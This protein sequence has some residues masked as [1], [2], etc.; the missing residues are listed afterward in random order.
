[1]AGTLSV[2]LGI[3]G[4]FLPILPT[5][6]FLLL[7]TACYSRSSVK[8]YNW[9]LNN[10]WFGNYL[11][12]YRAGKG[13]PIRIKVWAILVL[14]LTISYSALFMIENFIISTGLFLIAVIATYHIIKIRTFKQEEDPEIKI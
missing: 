13:V 4:I 8:F 6:P 10:R 2:G 5:T 14:W 11:K 9:L 12:N 7:A 1:L 3:L